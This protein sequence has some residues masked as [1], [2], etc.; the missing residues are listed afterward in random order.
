MRLLADCRANA[1]TVM[2]VLAAVGAAPTCDE[3]ARAAL[4]T[5]RSDFGWAYGSYWTVDPQERA[6]KFAVESG[7]VNDEFRRVTTSASFREGVGLSGRAWKQR[8]LVF[9][10]DIGQMT[11]C[12]RASIAQR[13]G[14]KSGVCFPILANGEV[15]GTMD[16]F[17]LTTLSLSEERLE[18]L[19]SVGNLVSGT[20]ARIRETDKQAAAAASA[21]AVIKVL[22]AVGEASTV[23]EAAKL[24]LDTVRSAGGWDYGS[25]WTVDPQERVLKFTVE[26]GSVNDEFR[27][28]T[29]SASFREGV[30]LSGRA[31]KQRDLVFTADIGQMTDCC[32]ASVAQRAG[33]KSGVCFP[34]L[35]QGQV[36]GTMD[37]FSLKTLNPSQERLHALRTVGRLVSAALSRI[38]DAKKQEQ[39]AADAG[40][41]TKVLQAVGEATSPD[42][43]ARAALETVRSAFGWAYGSYWTVDPQERVLKFT[44]ESGSVNDEFRRV[45]TSASFREGVGLSGRA[46]KQR[47]LVFTADIGRMTD[48][49]RAPVAQRAGV[50]SGVCFPILADGEVVATMDFFSLETLNPSKERLEALR[51]VGRMVSAALHRLMVEQAIRENAGALASSS[52]EL[53]AASQQ[54]S[55]NAEETAAQAGVVSA[56]AEQ[57]SKNVQTVATGMEEMSASIKEIAKNSAEAARVAQTAVTAAETT[58]ATMNKLGES[59]AEIGAVIKVITSIAEQTNL[60]ALNATIEAARAGEAGKGFAV[61]ANEVKELAKETAKATEDIRQKIEAIQLKTKEGVDATEQISS[62]IR[63]I[64]DIQGTIAGAVEEQTA[65]TNEMGRNVAEAAKG[66]SEI[67][68]NITAVAEAAQQMTEGSSNSLGAAQELSRMADELQNIVDGGKGRAET[69]PATSRPA[70][71]GGKGGATM[72][73]HNRLAGARA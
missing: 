58:S 52:E 15:V 51:S 35:V 28:V 14:F 49:C 71:A 25:Y 44:V 63:Q 47:D 1:A 17:S 65:T 34:I 26:S 9:T 36:V 22:E 29:T 43:A 3:A 16:F 21:A 39:S 23:T 33:V 42:E 11:D 45:T 8:D 67:A 38:E 57:V 13:A 2:N 20:M 54:M 18:T 72:N 27:R 68:Q 64:N 7:S 56:A 66:S 24:A 31:W 46:W 32:R 12:S 40:A 69:A 5:V 62:I 30:G 37:F 70:R 61:V 4:E 41:V 73:G 53:S 10:A 59:S 19:R 55:A 60:L 6:L 50:K 48:C